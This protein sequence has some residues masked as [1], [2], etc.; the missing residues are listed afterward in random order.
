MPVFIEYPVGLSQQDQTDLQL[1]YAD[2]PPALLAPFDSVEQLLLAAQQDG[3]VVARFNGRLLAAALLRKDSD[4]WQMS[5][6]CVRG[7]TRRRGVARRLL[8]EVAAAA[9][10]NAA[11]LSVQPVSAPGWLLDWLAREFPALAQINS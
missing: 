8:S 9:T 10:N 3:L 7:L 4:S 11:V 6:L 5:H 2:L 1:I